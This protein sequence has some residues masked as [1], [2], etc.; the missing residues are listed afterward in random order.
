[1]ATAG[2]TKVQTV[3]NAVWAANPVGIVIVAIGA[4]IAIFMLLWN[5]SESFRNFWIGLWDSIKKVV[6]TAVNFIV[7]CLEILLTTL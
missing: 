4:L 2:L 7:Q 3:L 6:S 5:N 1:M